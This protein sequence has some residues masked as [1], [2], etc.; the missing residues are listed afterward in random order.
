MHSS[1]LLIPFPL[2]RQNEFLYVLVIDQAYRRIT[3]IPPPSRLSIG[4]CPQSAASAT[5]GQSAKTRLAATYHMGIIPSHGNI[6]PLTD[7]STQAPV[8]DSAGVPK[9]RELRFRSGLPA[10]IGKLRLQNP[11]HAKEI[12]LRYAT[13]AESSPSDLS[14]CPCSFQR[15]MRGH[16]LQ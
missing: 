5:L 16:F 14:P 9:T 11:V 4:Y 10:K 2:L 3:G 12:D 15:V 7:P 8:V 13:G 1:S 6:V